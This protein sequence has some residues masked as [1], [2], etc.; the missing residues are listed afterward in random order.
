MRSDRETSG[1]RR[2]GRG[3]RIG[4]ISNGRCV[5]EIPHPEICRARGQYADEIDQRE[6][7]RRADEQNPL[8]RRTIHGS[9]A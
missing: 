6:D 7:E 9:A 3:T 1:T 8:L 4:R 5:V 2:S